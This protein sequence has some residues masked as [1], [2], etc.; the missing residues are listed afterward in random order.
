[1]ITQLFCQFYDKAAVLI[2]NELPKWRKR[3]RAINDDVNESDHG[4]E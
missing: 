2:W 1:M 3:I 4:V